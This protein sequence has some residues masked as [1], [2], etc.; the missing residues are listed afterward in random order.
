MRVLGIT[1]GI[2]TGKSTV[3]RMLADLGAPT[4][5]ADTLARDLLAPG[6]AVTQAVLAAF[7]ACA[8]PADHQT[9]DRRALSHLVFA[10]PSARAQLDAL[11][12]PAIIAALQS[13][14]AAWHHSS[15]AQ[16][17]AAEIPLLFEVGLDA[18]VDS[19]VVVTCTDFLQITRLQARLGVDEAEA[20]RQLA[21][22]WPLAEKAARA[23][24]L[25]TT[26]GDLAETKKQVETLWNTL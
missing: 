24:F 3:T 9:I 17:A 21:A 26:D 25:I 4:I 18:Q 22:Q 23:D 12:H 10:D 20:R 13:Q 1:G 7:P 19:V 11:T 8:D 6:T 5:S 15:A 16:A 14:I 2:A